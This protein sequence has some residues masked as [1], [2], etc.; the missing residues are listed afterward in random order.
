MVRETNYD[1]NC[2][3]IITWMY[4]SS[5]SKM[6][7]DG[8]KNLQ[9]PYLCTDATCWLIAGGAHHTVLSYNAPM[10]TTLWLPYPASAA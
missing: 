2:A 4:T 7:I 3:G 10:P 9:K 6:W 8:L 1:H 5:L